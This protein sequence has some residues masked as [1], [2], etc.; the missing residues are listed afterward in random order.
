MG[1][2]GRRRLCIEASGGRLTAY[3]LDGAD[4]P[5]RRLPYGD[6]STGWGPRIAVL[7]RPS[8]NEAVE[9]AAARQGPMGRVYRIVR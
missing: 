5:V 8:Y 1:F 7:R 2:S 4:I 6:R 3:A 9:G